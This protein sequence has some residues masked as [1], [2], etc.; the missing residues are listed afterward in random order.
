V[1]ENRK[2]LRRAVS[3]IDVSIVGIQ[4]PI[5][6]VIGYLSGRWLDRTLGTWPW[7][8]LLFSLFGV[9]AGFLNLFRIA[10][11]AERDEEQERADAAGKGSAADPRQGPPD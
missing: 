4:F 3:W 9:A 2:R 7:L 6:I 5:A 1:G 11:R 10:A 8:T